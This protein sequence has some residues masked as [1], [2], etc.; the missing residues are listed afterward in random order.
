MPRW[1]WGAL[2]AECPARG[3]ATRE[4]KGMKALGGLLSGFGVLMIAG[5]VV[6]AVVGRYDLSEAAGVQQFIGGAAAG[7]LV[8]ALG[9]ALAK[10]RNRKG[11][12]GTGAGNRQV[13]CEYLR[14]GG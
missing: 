7:L 4:G 1:V 9:L 14:E 2:V 6:L 13:T 8:V 5:A 3:A 10:P 11:R 12:K